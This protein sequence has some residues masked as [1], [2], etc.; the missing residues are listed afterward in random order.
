[1]ATDFLRA[2]EDERRVHRWTFGV[3]KPV[4]FATVAPPATDF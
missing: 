2:A 4:K 3:T 1:M